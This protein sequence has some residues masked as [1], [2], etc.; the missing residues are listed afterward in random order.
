VRAA[1][2]LAV[3]HHLRITVRCGGHCYEDFVS[4]NNGGVIIDLAPLRCIS[5]ERDD[6]Y[7]VDGGCTLWDVST[8]L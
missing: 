4:G 1:V 5:R 2:Q 3:D 7:G 8:Q 6:R